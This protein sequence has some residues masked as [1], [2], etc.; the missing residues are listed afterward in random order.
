MTNGARDR[1]SR[2]LRLGDPHI[3]HHP[4]RIGD[5]F[6]DIELDQAC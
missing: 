3:E 2:Q 6:H 4:N 5:T 1:R